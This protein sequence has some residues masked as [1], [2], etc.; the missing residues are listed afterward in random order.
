[1][2]T[3][4][5]LGEVLESDS[6]QGSFVV[7]NRLTGE[8]RQRSLADIHEEVAAAQISG[9]VPEEVRSAFATAQNL[10]VYSWFV[11]AFGVLADRQ[12]YAV[13][14][15]ALRLRLDP[16]GRRPRLGLRGLMKE[17]IRMML[18]VDHGVIELVLPLVGTVERAQ[19]DAE[20]AR[21]DWDAQQYVKRL[22][23]SFG[24]LRNHL[25]HGNFALWPGQVLT[26]HLV[27]RLIDQVFS[28]ADV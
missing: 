27:A 22:V 15:L 23:D 8:V 21:P 26:L 2:E 11:Y 6:R 20:L 4:K 12:A 10:M 28:R 3:L 16:E 24:Q 7:R 1:M 9:Q 17:A 25:A 19:L 5:P 18:L 14:E 13:L